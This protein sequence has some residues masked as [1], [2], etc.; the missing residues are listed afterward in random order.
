[1]P[2]RAG[3]FDGVRGI[4]AGAF[5]DASGTDVDAVITERLGSLGVPVV[6]GVPIGHVPD[7]RPVPLG[8]PARLDADAGTLVLART[9]LT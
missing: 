8:V 6:S 9:A 4:A 7:N 3:W 2:P 1:M 5:T